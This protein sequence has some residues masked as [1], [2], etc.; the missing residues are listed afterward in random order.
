MVKN[1]PANAGDLGSTPVSGRSP[2][3]G[4]GNLLKVFLPGKS[5]GHK[6]LAPYS[7][8]GH[9]RAGHDLA[10]KQQPCLSPSSGVDEGVTL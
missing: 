6:S 10:T 3:E 7:P 9:K 5:H 8:W 2:R 4:D 1:P